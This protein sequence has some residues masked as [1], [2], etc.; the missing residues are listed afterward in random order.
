MSKRKTH[1]ARPVPDDIDTIWRTYCG[2]EIADAE[3][4]RPARTVKENELVDAWRATCKV[5]QATGP[6]RPKPAATSR[7]PHEWARQTAEHI[8][9]GAWLTSG[10]H[11]TAKQPKRRTKRQRGAA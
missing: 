11:S 5:C 2:R 3:S 6:K 9:S 10:D 1:A 7:D 8:S 4:A